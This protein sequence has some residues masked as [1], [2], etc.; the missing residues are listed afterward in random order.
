MFASFSVTPGGCCCPRRCSARRRS[1]LLARRRAERAR[2]DPAGKVRR[3]PGQARPRARERKLAGA[4]RSPN[5]TAAIDSM[6]GEVSALRQR[7]GRGRG[8]TRRKAGRARRGD[9]RSS[10]PTSDHLA[11]VRARLQRALDVLRDRLV[12]IY[13][14]GSPDVLNVVLESASW[15]E[16]SARADYLSQIQDY[17][18]S[19]AEPGQG[20]ARRSAGRGRADDRR[21]PRRSRTRATRSPP[22][23]AKSPPPAPQPR[24]ASPN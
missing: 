11:E 10:K 8:R 7:A 14:A 2:R 1:A 13:E 24:P 15:S 19:V 18:D 20:P 12:A 21:P 17:D 23:S 5:R 16:V 4:T 22:R 6:L 3:H 9:R